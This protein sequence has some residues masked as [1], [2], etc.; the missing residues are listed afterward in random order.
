[1]M[2]VLALLLSTLRIAWSNAAADCDGESCANPDLT[3]QDLGSD[4]TS[5]LQMRSTRVRSGQ[6]P[7]YRINLDLAPEQRW[8][9]VVKDYRAESIAMLKAVTKIVDTHFGDEVAA[10]WIANTHF[11]EFPEYE[12][13]LKGFVAL[14]NDSSYTL[15]RAF[16][17][18]LLYEMGN[19]SACSGV[20]WAL[21]NGTV[22]HG[23]NMDYRLKF[24]MPDGRKLDLP[25][26]TFDYVAYKGGKPLYAATGWPG[27]IGPIGVHT[28]MRFGGWSFQQNTRLLKNEWKENLEA[29]KKGG[30]AWSWAVRKVLETVPDYATA[31][32]KLYDGNY[33]SPM[34]FIIA[35]SGSYEGAV[36]TIDRLGHHSSYTPKIARIDNSSNGWHL[37]QTN[38]DLGADALTPWDPRRPMANLYLETAQQKVVS[39]EHLMKFLHTPFLF[40]KETVFS[41]V[42]IPATGYYKTTLPTEGPSPLD[43]ARPLVVIAGLKDWAET[44]A[45]K[46]V[47]R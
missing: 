29:A 44:S 13:E 24:T 20:L 15:R 12:A 18:Q 5:L 7:F 45:A 32:S 47:L 34:Y 2:F 11:D 23:R 40:N 43:E 28:A 30:K 41:T 36:L 14:V 33:M 39:K 17:G 25:D 4:D 10:E 37:V 19:P 3:D 26:V 9:E 22:L 16:L 46:A 1:M 21:P 8:A 31:L 27:A 42:M 38:E 6:V 35:G